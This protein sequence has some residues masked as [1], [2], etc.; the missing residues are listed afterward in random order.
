MMASG[1]GENRQNRGAERGTSNQTVADR[2]VVVDTL[3][4]D[5]VFQSYLR[6]HV[7]T[8]GWKRLVVSS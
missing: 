5:K 8:K 4:V 3:Q 2:P 1:T 6:I 7:K